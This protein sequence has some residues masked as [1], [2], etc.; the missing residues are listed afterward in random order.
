M[1]NW[2][3]VNQTFLYDGTFYGLLTIVFDCFYHKTLPVKIYPKN[4][5]IPNFLDKT[6][7]IMTNEKKSQRVF[8]GIYKHIG[9]QALY[10]SFYAFLSN[11]P[12]KEIDILKYLCDG[13]EIGP[14]INDRITLSYVANVMAMRK[15]ALS[16]CHR[17]K[18][19]LRF[20]ETNQHIFYASIHPDNNILEPLGH[21]FMRRLSSQDFV[22][23]D[24]NHHLCF[25][26]HDDQYQIIEDTCFQLPDL[27]QEE[28]MYQK[29]WQTFFHTISIEE[30]KN[31]RCQMQFMPKK[32]WR[33]LIEKPI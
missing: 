16:E 9:Y 30:R 5:Y 31:P 3:L 32:Y 10:N 11:A 20:V 29:L 25:L 27:S 1:S 12:H 33:D 21:H 22:I 13:F 15:R 8:D 26:Y 4:N 24:Q 17:L 23:H 28:E 6:I 18:G 14:K 7:E 19:L 2:K